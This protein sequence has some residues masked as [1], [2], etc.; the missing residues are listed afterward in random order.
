MVPRL[1]LSLLMSPPGID[2]EWPDQSLIE[3]MDRKD[4]QKIISSKFSDEEG[5]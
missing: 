4:K 3:S 2:G 1:K 5:S